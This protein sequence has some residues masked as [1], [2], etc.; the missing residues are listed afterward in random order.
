[1]LMLVNSIP[2]VDDNACIYNIHCP[3]L[4]FF[5]GA[6][7]VCVSFVGYLWIGAQPM[8]YPLYCPPTDLDNLKQNLS[9]FAYLHAP[10]SHGTPY[11]REGKDVPVFVLAL[12]EIMPF[13]NLPWLRGKFSSDSSRIRCIRSFLQTTWVG[14]STI[15]SSVTRTRALPCIKKETA[16][17][18]LQRIMTTCP[19]WRRGLAYLRILTRVNVCCGHSGNPHILVTVDY[20]DRRRE[21][22][23]SCW[24]QAL[25]R[26]NIASENL[27]TVLTRDTQVPMSESAV[28]A[29]ALPWLSQFMYDNRRVAVRSMDDSRIFGLGNFFGLAQ[30]HCIVDLLQMFIHPYAHSLPLSVNSFVKFLENQ[31][32]KELAY[33]VIFRT[34][35]TCRVRLTLA[36]LEPQIFRNATNTPVDTLAL[37]GSCCYQALLARLIAIWGTVDVMPDYP[38]ASQVHGELRETAIMLILQVEDPQYV[39]FMGKLG[40]LCTITSPFLSTYDT[41]SKTHFL[42]M[43]QT[44]TALISWLQKQD[45]N[46]LLA[47][48]YITASVLFGWVDTHDLI[49]LLD[50]S[51]REVAMQTQLQQEEERSC[52]AFRSRGGCLMEHRIHRAQMEVSLFSNAIANLSE[53]METRFSIGSNKLGSTVKDVAYAGACAVPSS[54]MFDQCRPMK[55]IQDKC[56]AWL[57]MTSHFQGIVGPDS[58][59]NRTLFGFPQTIDD[60]PYLYE[61]FQGLDDQFLSL[62]RLLRTWVDNM[63]YHAYMS[64]S[65]AESGSLHIDTSDDF[66]PMKSKTTDILKSDMHILGLKKQRAQAEVDMFSEALACIAEFE[67]TDDGTPPRSAVTHASLTSDDECLDDCFSIS[68]TS[69]Y[70]SIIM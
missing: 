41:S 31:M 27:E 20:A 23:R 65:F 21:L 35:A 4:Q 5:A 50:V 55:A 37:M 10:M 67:G 62:P 60:D 13:L 40:E 64:A 57:I 9:L 8:L 70:G 3:G 11:E 34:T 66:Q 54:I 61:S 16:R 15:D 24:P 45:R 46:S 38:S 18:S 36:D 53:E 33:H 25:I 69:S 7:T 49:V 48:L 12:P 19:N 63:T 17:H 68:Y 39:P 26:A 32:A 47:S 52:A 58:H 56:N 30:R 1:M 14:S 2:S 43:E 44:E 59:A 28:L 6:P 42:G 51:L 29:L 22:L